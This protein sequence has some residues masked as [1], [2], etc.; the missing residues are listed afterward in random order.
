MEHLE[1]EHEPFERF[2]MELEDFLLHLG[3]SLVALELSEAYSWNAEQAPDEVAWLFN[4]ARIALIER[5]PATSD[6]WERNYRAFEASVNAAG[7]YLI[8]AF[9]TLARR[10]G[11]AVARDTFAAI[12][13][14]PSGRSPRPL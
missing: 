1:M 11:I 13:F 10:H 8:R 12:R 6:H 14:D 9:V 5:D 3:E 7:W 2:E 4:A